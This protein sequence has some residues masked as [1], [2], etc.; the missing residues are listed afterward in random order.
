MATHIWSILTKRKSLWVDWVYDYRLK[1]KSFWVCKMPANCSWSWRMLL[2]LRPLMRDHFR[3]QIGDGRMTSAWYDSWSDV[4][5]LGNFISPRRITNAGFRL[6]DSVA[7]VFD[8]GEWLWPA[9]WWDIFPVLI[10]LDPI[11]LSPNKRDTIKWKDGNTML[12][13]SASNMWQTVRHN[14]AE[15][16]WSKLVWCAKCIPRH[17]FLMWLIMRKK[18]LTQD[19]ILQWDLSRRKNMNM[20]CCL[21]CYENHDSHNHLFFECKYSSKIWS[22]VRQKVGMEDVDPKWDDVVGWLLMRVNSKAAGMY[23]SRILVAATAYFIWQ[24]RNS[25][26]FKNQLRPPEQLCQVILDTVRYKLMG[27]RLK[28]T[29]RV[30]TLL[31]DWD[32][33]DDG[34]EGG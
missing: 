28:R 33:H 16:D 25:R 30:A 21:L 11:Q 24:E 14:E 31:Q 3:V 29:D 20:M 26:L 13:V 10:Q 5:P 9:A 4:G 15:V 12:E 23:V 1:G 2:Q 6:E 18:L 32:I 19:I 7:D 22:T 34:F 27:V 8:N 17:A